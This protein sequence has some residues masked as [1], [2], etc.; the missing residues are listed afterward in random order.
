M[1]VIG[2]YDYLVIIFYFAFMVGVGLVFRKFNKDISDYFR[3][4]GT[5]VWWM[6]GAA[7]IMAN[8]SVWSFTGAAAKIYEAGT[9]VAMVWLVT[10]SPEFLLPRLL[11]DVSGKCG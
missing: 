10:L 8:L 1:N 5:M 3:G 6:T 2:L 4:G 7:T 11:P 9:V